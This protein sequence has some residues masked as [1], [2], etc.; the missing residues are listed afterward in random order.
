MIIDIIIKQLALSEKS[1]LEIK[2]DTKKVIKIKRNL[3]IKFVCFFI[4]SFSLV[5][6][7]WFYIGCFCAVYSNTQ[8]YLLKDTLL[9]FAISLIFPFIKYLLSSILRI[10]S[11]KDKDKYLKCLYDVSKL[12][13]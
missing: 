7:F 5:G 12:L 9:S 4:I 10:K 11:L 3:L 2:N 1:I 8:I 6:I 13:Q